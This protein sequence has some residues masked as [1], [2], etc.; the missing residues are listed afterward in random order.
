MFFLDPVSVLTN[1][2][3]VLPNAVINAVSSLTVLSLICLSTVGN[4]D[5]YWEANNIP[6]LNDGE[7]TIGE[8]ANFEPFNVNY[9]LDTDLFFFDRRFIQL[10]SDRTYLGSVVTGS[11]SCK[12]RESN[13]S[14][15]GVYLT[16]TNPLW[17]VLSAVMDTVPMGAQVNIT[18]QYGDNS[19]GYR[20]QGTGFTYSLIFVPCVA[21]QPDVALLAG[22]SDEFSNTL[23]FSFRARLDDDSGEYM[24]NG[25]LAVRSYM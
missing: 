10:S 24:W 15:S 9:V 23:E 13:V 17:Q 2:E 21:T 16:T 25:E 14:S 5:L 7:I 11:L 12:S 4:R 1:G 20:N 3:E 8:A 19:N 18:L 6:N 22:T